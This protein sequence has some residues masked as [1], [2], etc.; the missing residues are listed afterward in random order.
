MC[1][2][3]QL[4]H[5]YFPVTGTADASSHALLRTSSEMRG[6]IV[7]YTKKE[8]TEEDLKRAEGSVWRPNIFLN[9]GTLQSFWFL[10]FSHVLCAS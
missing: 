5:K 6:T 2:S 1:F 10:D 4:L 3:Y 9:L 7:N 8:V